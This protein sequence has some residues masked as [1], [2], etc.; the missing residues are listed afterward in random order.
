MIQA[1]L[2][3]VG[4]TLLHFATSK[5]RQFLASGTRGAYDRLGELGYRLPAYEKYGR[6][7]K[8]SFQWAYLFSRIRRR[9]AQ[10]LRVFKRAHH[11]MGVHVDDEQMNDLALRITSPF[12]RLFAM[13]EDAADVVARLDAA[14]L[15]LGLVSNTLFPGFA[16]DDF[17]QC[18]GLLEYF[19]VRI[20]SSD[21]GYMKPHRKIFRLALDRL[22]VAASRTLFVGDRLDKD[23]KGPSRVGMRTALLVRNGRAPRGRVR[24]DHIIRSL[25]EVPAIV[26]M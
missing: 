23:V 11:R 7:I 8:R 10:L 15:K 3:D 17:L 18:E 6:A 13:D 14:R 12:R 19:P 24:P 22:G 26:D 4:D 21:V 9:E 2:F 1:V 16:I 25:A 5:A 20:Y